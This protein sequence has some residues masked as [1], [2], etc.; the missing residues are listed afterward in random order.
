MLIVDYPFQM[1]RTY[2]GTQL[3]NTPESVA[4]IVFVVK[5]SCEIFQS[6][7]ECCTLGPPTVLPLLVL[8]SDQC[9]QRNFPNPHLVLFWSLIEIVFPQ[10][11][12]LFWP[13]SN[14]APSIRAL[15]LL[16]QKEHCPRTQGLL[17]Y[18]RYL[19]IQKS[20]N[21]WPYEVILQPQQCNYACTTESY[22][23]FFPIFRA[24]CTTQHTQRTDTKK[25]R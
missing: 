8:S 24:M 9:S 16:A 14:S 6:K 5:Q 21:L 1:I 13:I 20:F 15:F 17:T 25:I 23:I 12:A 11:S 18:L 3:Q 19:G 7:S 4:T 22:Y 10:I 2:T